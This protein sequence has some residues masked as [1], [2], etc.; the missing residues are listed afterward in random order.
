MVIYPSQIS[1]GVFWLSIGNSPLTKEEFKKA[2]NKAF[3]KDKPNCGFLVASFNYTQTAQ[4]K[5][6]KEE[7]GFV[8]WAG[9]R[10]NPNHNHPICLLALP[11][12]DE[13]LPPVPGCKD[14]SRR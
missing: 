9:W 14:C 5:F 8:Q 3:Y 11:I 13:K 7:L 6:C 1:C 2:C 12:G 10:I 4:I